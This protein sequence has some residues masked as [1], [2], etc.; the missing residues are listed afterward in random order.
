M[1]HY[2]P[3]FNLPAL[4]FDC[5]VSVTDNGISTARRAQQWERNCR[6]GRLVD[7][8]HTVIVDM[9]DTADIVDTVA[10][11]GVTGVSLVQW[12]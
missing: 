3:A 2:L 8:V 4:I 5:E 12:Q 7:T 6:Y 10:S 1:L 11:Y 9:V